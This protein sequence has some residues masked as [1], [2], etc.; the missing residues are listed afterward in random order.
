MNDNDVLDMVRDSM[1]GVHMRTPAAHVIAAGRARRRNR[2]GAAI[3]AGALLAVGL[4][5]TT[6]LGNSPPPGGEVHLHLAAFSVD[7][8]DDGTVTVKLTKRETLDPTV[9]QGA[10]AQAGVPTQITINKWCQPTQRG[11]N[12]DD[13][14]EK[15]VSE[16]KQSDGTT[17]T[18][19]TP[20]AMP[21]NSQLVIG[22]RTEGYQPESPSP[23][24]VMM[25]LVPDDAP[26]TCTTD[27]PARPA[28]GNGPVPAPEPTKP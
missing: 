8:N 16:E 24:A 25:Y 12:L 23:L 13:D 2:R 3:T 4:A 19:F 21:A 17:V 11:D 28:R 1:A 26:L 10:L 14:F 20:S 6:G 5:W 9:L 15:V 22:M 7:T 27:V 18:V